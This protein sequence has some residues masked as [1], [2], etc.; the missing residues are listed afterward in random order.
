MRT[1]DSTPIQLD[2]DVRDALFNL[3]PD[4][5]AEPAAAEVPAEEAEEAPAAE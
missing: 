1:A 2:T 4:P 3:T 5:A